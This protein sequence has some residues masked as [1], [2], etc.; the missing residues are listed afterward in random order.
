M[1]DLFAAN[2][3][4]TA[5]TTERDGYKDERDNYKTK[6]DEYDRINTK[7]SGK[8]SDSDLDALSNSTPQCSHTDYDTIKSE[9]DA[10][11]AEKTET[12]KK[13]TSELGLAENSTLEQILAKVKDLMKTP[14]TSDKDTKITELQTQI[15]QKDQT[16][17]DLQKLKPSTEIKTELIKNSKELGIFTTAYQQKLEQVS[18]Y[19][20]L[21]Q[22][23]QEAFKE[24]LLEKETALTRIEGNTKQLKVGLG[25]LI[26]VMVLLSLGGVGYYLTR[27]KEVK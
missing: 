27:K 15:T 10:L 18:S 3:A 7:L 16:I 20:E 1:T 12:N 21:S 9:R 8:V 5:L 24:K 22:I 13:I 14:D 2:A 4:F 19:Q 11:T 25:V 17:A 26:V 6:S 23:Q